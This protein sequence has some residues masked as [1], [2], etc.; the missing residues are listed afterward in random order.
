MGATKL[1]TKSDNTYHVVSHSAFSAPKCYAFFCD[2][3]LLQKMQPLV[4]SVALIPPVAHRHS[5]DVISMAMRNH[6]LGS[7][8][9]A[10]P[11]NH[12]PVGGLL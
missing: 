11:P 12:Y 2:S 3:L 6:T 5:R 9:L 1:E 7:A 8:D 10:Q 4:H